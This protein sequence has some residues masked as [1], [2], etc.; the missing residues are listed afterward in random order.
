M[1][2]RYPIFL[3]LSGKKCVI[4]G[5]GYEVAGKVRALMEASAKVL[6]VNQE[7]VPEINELAVQG[8]IQ[9]ERREFRPDDLDD[10]F[11]V[12]TSGPNNA[13]VF[14]LA[15]AR[16]VICNAVDDPATGM[17]AIRERPTRMHCTSAGLCQT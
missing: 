16:G 9:W 3:D 4:A 5:E 2:F 12:I 11:L 17:E 13:E 6:Y 7:A 15:E 1:N 8:A 10:C 14:R